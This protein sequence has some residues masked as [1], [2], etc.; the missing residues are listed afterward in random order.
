MLYVV[1]VELWSAFD[2]CWM[3]RE[4]ERMKEESQALGEEG[5]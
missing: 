5:G 2:S 4:Q 3:S 1:T